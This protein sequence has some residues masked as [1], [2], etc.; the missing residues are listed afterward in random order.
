[1]LGLYG[2]FMTHAPERRTRRLPAPD[3]RVEY[4]QLRPMGYAERR[5]I[6][7]KPNRRR[8]IWPRD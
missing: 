3:E 2:F 4:Q 6:K 1:L 5:V 7:R 8:W